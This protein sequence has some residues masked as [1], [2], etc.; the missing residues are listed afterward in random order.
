MDPI[1]EIESLTII[2]LKLNPTHLRRLLRFAEN[3]AAVESV[4]AKVQA[5]REAH[6]KAAGYVPLTK[7]K[8]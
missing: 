8:H 1:S 7:G 2:A 5:D 6:F 3:L 4:E